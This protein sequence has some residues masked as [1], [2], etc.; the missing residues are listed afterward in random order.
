MSL[1]PEIT[2]VR[3][4]VLAN[5][6][7]EECSSLFMTGGIQ[8]GKENEKGRKHQAKRQKQPQPENIRLSK[9]IQRISLTT[10]APTRRALYF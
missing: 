4:A 5:D 10:S 9:R 8:D 6:K 7:G 1:T 2:S 3:Y